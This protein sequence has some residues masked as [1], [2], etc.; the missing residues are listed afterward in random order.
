MNDN[1][2]GYDDYDDSV[3]SKPREAKQAKSLAVC[4]TASSTTGLTTSVVVL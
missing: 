2:N 3:L 4:A 1:D